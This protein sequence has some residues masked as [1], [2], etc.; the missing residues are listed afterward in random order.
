MG[1]RRGEQREE[2][3]RAGGDLGGDG[4][5]IPINDVTGRGEKMGIRAENWENIKLLDVKLFEIRIGEFLSYI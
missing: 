5:P 2:F 4:R 3:R 1:G